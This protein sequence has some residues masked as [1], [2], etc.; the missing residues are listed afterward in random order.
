MAYDKLHAN[1]RKALESNGFK[2]LSDPLSFRHDGLKFFIDLEIERDQ[3]KYAIEI[4]SFNNSFLAEFYK[5][6]GQILVYQRVMK[7]KKMNHRLYLGMT[8]DMFKTY[9]DEK[10]PRLILTRYHI[11]ILT[12]SLDK[13][14]IAFYNF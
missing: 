13:K 6:L 4:K 1:I 8:Q 3:Q 12:V 7:I 5:M 14:N 2:T 9:L 10:F 11:N